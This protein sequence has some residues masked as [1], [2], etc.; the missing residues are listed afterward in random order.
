MS[1][2]RIGLIGC[3]R[4][5]KNIL[6]DLQLLGA[7]VVVVEPSPDV[8][9]LVRASGAAH[10]ATISGL[11]RVDGLIVATPAATHVD[12]VEECLAFDVPIFVEKPFTLDYPSA[13]ALAARAPDRLFVMH[14]WRYHPG[15]EAIRDL[16]RDQAFGPVEWV[17]SVRANWTSPRTDVDSVWTMLPHD[18][19]MVF[20][21]FGVL[22][23]PISAVAEWHT[24]PS[25]AR[26]PTGIIAVL[27]THPAVVLETSTRYGDKRREFRV[28][29]RDA[30]LDLTGT[31]SDHVTV[32]RVS[33]PHPTDA[34]I[35]K[36]PISTRPALI[37]ELEAFLDHLTGGPAPRSGMQDA[38]KITQAVVNIRRMAGIDA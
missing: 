35:E 9:A 2:L 32:H 37:R 29:C 3:G 30:V 38:L 25:G 33:N 1:D 22:P 15:V 5:G 19:S 13:Q 36:I 23:D 14:V 8:G 10:F 21:M 27:G 12:V 11:P 20:E 34:I 16:V 7:E 24:D 28:H 6:R 4:W 18:V 31:D 26:R 17:K